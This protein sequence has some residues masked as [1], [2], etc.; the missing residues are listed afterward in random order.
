MRELG[1]YKARPMSRHQIELLAKSLRKILHI[2]DEKWIDIISIF[3]KV[4]PAIDEEFS[5]EIVEDSEL[6]AHAR[7]YPEEHL[8]K[9]RESVYNGARK[10]N[11]RDRF[12][13]AH[14]IGH[15][16]LHGKG[17]ISL[18]RNPSD[19]K[20]YEDPEWQASVF[21][22]SLL[23][24]KQKIEGMDIHEVMDACGVSYPAAKCQLDVIKKTGNKSYL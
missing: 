12:T 5:Y 3:E 11:G 20:K 15:Y 19:I 14:E 24:D 17:E 4:L 7:T 6:D 8:I 18:A 23:M 16:L 2:Q 1:L 22:G 10:G 13:I 9:V 21:A